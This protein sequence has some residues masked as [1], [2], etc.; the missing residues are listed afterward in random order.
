MGDLAY[1]IGITGGSAS[2]KTL[3]LNQ[4][5]NKF[6]AGDV[7][8]ISQDNYYIDRD[9]QPLDVNGIQNFDLPDS[10]DS[11][12]FVEDIRKIKGGQGFTRKEY[13][14]NNP[15]IT[16][17]QLEFKPAPIV[18]VEG[19]FV[20]HFPEMSD[21]LDLKIFIDAKDHIRLKRRI[22]RDNTERGY[23]LDDVLYRFE[24][25]VMPTYDR[26]LEPLKS[27][28]DLIIPNNLHFNNALEVLSGFLHARLK[29]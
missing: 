27:G 24:N 3:F 28:A 16:P 8:L 21:L 5:I 14:F 4:L 13:T 19:L 22:I 26:Y 23:D 17:K 11:K 18:I 20:M 12:A 9:K 2:G 6:E 7:C 29:L 10:I 15:A 1:V 25:H